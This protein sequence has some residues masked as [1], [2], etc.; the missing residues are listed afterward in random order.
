MQQNLNTMTEQIKTITLNLETRFKVIEL[1]QMDYHNANWRKN[2]NAEKLQFR[3]QI[4]KLKKNRL[5]RS[6]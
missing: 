4:L 6:E 5:K 3:I 1:L 2:T